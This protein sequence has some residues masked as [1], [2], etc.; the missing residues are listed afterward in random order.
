MS[1]KLAW[2]AALLTSRSMPPSSATAL[3]MTLRQWV[4]SWMSPGM[5]TAFRP[6]SPGAVELKRALQGMTAAVDV[7]E[8][9]HRTRTGLPGV[10]RFVTT[11]HGI[12]P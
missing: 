11:R 9:N 4:A 5:R 7:Q 2:W 12:P 1:L 8:M 10:F 6:A 3:S